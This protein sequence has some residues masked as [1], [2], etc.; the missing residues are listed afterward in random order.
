MQWNVPRDELAIG[1]HFLTVYL[2]CHR[3][4]N[5]LLRYRCRRPLT[6][7]RHLPFGASGYHQFNSETAKSVRWAPP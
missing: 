5:Q 2:T 7:T 4:G 6:G 1:Y 3:R